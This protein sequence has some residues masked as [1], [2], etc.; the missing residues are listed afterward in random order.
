M[1]FSQVPF[2]GGVTVLESLALVAQEVNEK[3]A[4]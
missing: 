3:Q 2:V 1:S 4:D